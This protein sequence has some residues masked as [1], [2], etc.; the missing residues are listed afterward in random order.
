MNHLAAAAYLVCVVGSVVLAAAAVSRWSRADALDRA[1][2]AGVAG[3]SIPV[4]SGLALGMVG[5]LSPGP[6]LV[7]HV[8]IGSVAAARL[9]R[10]EV[11]ERAPAAWSITGTTAVVIGCLLGFLALVPTLAG[12][13]TQ[14]H[15]TTAYHITNLVTWVNQHS[16]WEL[17]FQNTGFFTATHPGNGELL[18]APMLLATGSDQLVYVV[19]IVF[20]ALCVLGCAMIARELDARPDLGALAALALVGAPIVFGTQAHSLATD[21]PAAAGIAVGVAALLRARHSRDNRW[22]AVAG[23]ALGFAMGSKY[24]VLL[25]V[26]VIAGLAVLAQRRR[27]RTMAL[28]APGIVV[29]AGPWFLRNLVATGNPV[30]PQAVRIGGVEIFE[31]GD[32]PLLGLKTTLLDHVIHGNWSVVGLWADINRDLYGP[33]AVIAVIGLVFA[34]F[35][36]PQRRERVA[37]AGIG[38]LALFVYAITPYT[39]G[40]PD[41][42]AFLVGSNSRYTMT[43]AFLG[44]ALAVVVMPPRLLA[45]VTAAAFGFDAWKMARG[46]SFRTDLDVGAALA[47]IGVVALA[48]LLSAG[49]VALGRRRLAYGPV[50]L[51]TSGAASLLLV[52][53]A[54][55]QINGAGAPAHLER[56]LARTGR[57]DV[58]VLGVTDMRSVLGP[59]FDGD[60]RTVSAGGRAGERPPASREQLDQMVQSSDADVLVVQDGTP[61]VPAGWT[62]PAEYQRVAST[63]QGDVYER[64][65]EEKPAPSAPP[66]PEP[67]APS[68]PSAPEPPAP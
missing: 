17:P 66:A 62:P 34:W 68:T 3:I 6:F 59:R 31:G 53:V 42:L 46:Y 44:V 41:G 30:F 51:V 43:A 52:G 61:G 25:I 36:T 12:R 14:D 19:N 15:D 1:L 55:G 29:L 54:L 32:S 10:T 65:P 48:G 22:I 11:H 5:L 16:I 35:W 26:P 13:L 45:V 58:M 18:A 64:V 39:G 2:V 47:V 28:L 49:L 23:C 40:G 67:S 57:E 20:G 63:R 33:A 7:T 56:V 38:A 60:V 4:G 24:T 9:A 37:V 8:V 50:T 27:L 21:L